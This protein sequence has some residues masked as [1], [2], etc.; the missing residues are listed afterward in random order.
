MVLG[1]NRPYR[2]HPIR[3]RTW[4]PAA[5]ERQHVAWMASR[6]QFNRELWRPGSQ[7]RADRWQKLY[8][9]GIDMEGRTIASDHRTRLRVKP[10]AK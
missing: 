3:M 2:G 4:P 5:L 7:A 9:Q 6:D 8:Y 10:F 1:T